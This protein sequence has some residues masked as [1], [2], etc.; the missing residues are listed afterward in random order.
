MRSSIEL[1]VYKSTFHL[2]TYR[3]GASSFGRQRAVTTACAHL[4]QTRDIYVC[5]CLPGSLQVGGALDDRARELA[6]STSNLLFN[7]SQ[8]GLHNSSIAIFSPLP[9]A[10]SLVTLVGWHAQVSGRCARK[11]ADGS[12]ISRKVVVPKL[13]RAQFQRW[14]LAPGCPYSSLDHRFCATALPFCATARPVQ[15][16]SSTSPSNGDIRSLASVRNSSAC[17]SAAFGACAR[18][19]LLQKIPL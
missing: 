11:N 19:C 6:A 5:E 18:L 12:M 4:A 10:E 2:N 13:S 15:F 16:P 7:R 9:S 8:C 3:A 1:W 14:L 17:F